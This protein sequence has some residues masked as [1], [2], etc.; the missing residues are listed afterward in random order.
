MLVLDPA[1]TARAGTYRRWSERGASVAVETSLDR[2]LA[3]VRTGR[4]SL[5]VLPEDLG[6][7][8]DRAASDPQRAADAWAGAWCPNNVGRFLLYRTDERSTGSGDDVMLMGAASDEA[9]IDDALGRIRRRLK[10]AR[11]RR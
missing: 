1:P 2:A 7:E 6:G 10:T 11:G 8:I 9:A 3:R 5:I 4:F